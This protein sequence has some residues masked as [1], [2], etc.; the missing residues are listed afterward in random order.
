LTHAVTSS[1]GATLDLPR[2]T[3]GARCL[4]LNVALHGVPAPSGAGPDYVPPMPIVAVT[5]Y[6]GEAELSM[7]PHGGGGGGGQREDGT[8]DLGQEM[9]Y[10]LSTPLPADVPLPMV[11]ELTLDPSLG[12][13]APLRFA[14]QAQPDVSAQ[15]GFQGSDAP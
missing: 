14:L 2:L 13:E 3:H 4:R 8:F 1:T 10:V 15:C 11:L 7:Q 9:V 6:Y 5:L 12:F